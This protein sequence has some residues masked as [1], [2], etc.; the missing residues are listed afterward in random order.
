MF[1]CR[2][3]GKAEVRDRHDQKALLAREGRDVVV[4]L[5]SS[6]DNRE[7]RPSRSSENTKAPGFADTNSRRSYSTTRRRTL[8]GR[9]AQGIEA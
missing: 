2:L 4:S 8:A 9:R 3:G 7:P 1:G 5:S 6:Y